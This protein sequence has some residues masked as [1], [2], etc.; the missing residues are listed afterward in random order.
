[1]KVTSLYGLKGFRWNRIKL[2]IASV[3]AIVLTR[4]LMNSF[5]GTQSRHDL[6]DDYVIYDVGEVLSKPVFTYTGEDIRRAN[7]NIGISGTDSSAVLTLEVL[8]EKYSNS[9]TFYLHSSKCTHGASYNRVGYINTLNAKLKAKITTLIVPAMMK[10]S[11]S[12]CEGMTRLKRIIFVGQTYRIESSYDALKAVKDKYKLVIQ[13]VHLTSWGKGYAKSNTGQPTWSLVD[14]HYSS[15]PNPVLWDMIERTKQNANRGN[16]FINHA[17]FERG[18]N[19]AHEVYCRMHLPQ[20]SFK[21]LDYHFGNDSNILDKPFP[22]VPANHQYRTTQCA[23]FEMLGSMS[24]PDL[25]QQLAHSK[26][27]LYLLVLPN[28]LLHK[29]TFAIAVLEAVM[30]GVRV[31]TLPV[32]S[33]VELYTGLVDFVPISRWDYRNKLTSYDF[34]ISETDFLRDEFIESVVRYMNKLDKQDYESTRKRRMELA[35][36]RYSKERFQKAW[37]QVIEDY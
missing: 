37:V 28:G 6:E 11:E 4:T 36:R 8:A 35:S 26:Y 16:S 5:F 17:T 27:F 1:M 3:V 15:V 31:V 29:D 24:K 22:M 32:G 7:S 30:L 18:G 10:I 21:V 12:Y 34:F 2:L 9:K 19:I 33:L 23:G 13:Y 25:Y 14:R 20:S